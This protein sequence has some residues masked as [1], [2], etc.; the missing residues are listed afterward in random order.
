MA[1][2]PDTRGDPLYEKILSVIQEANH[3]VTIVTPYYIPDEVLQRSLMVKA[4]SGKQVKLVIPK[5]SNHPVT[6]LA[7]KTFYESW[8]NQ[9]WKYFYTERECYMGRR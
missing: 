1:S 8:L 2:G 9:V 5:K 7:R 3:F 4:R 6:D